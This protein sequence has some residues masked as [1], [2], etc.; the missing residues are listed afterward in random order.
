MLM[1]DISTIE[2]QESE[3]QPVEERRLKDYIEKF[4]YHLHSIFH[5]DE[6]QEKWHYVVDYVIICMIVLS[7]AEIFISTFNLNP[8]VKKLMF[9]IDML[10]LVFFTCEVTLRIWV[11]P[12]ANK[13]VPAW[14]ARCKY[15]F[16]FNGIIDM[17]STYPFY[18]QWLLPFPIAWMKLLRMGRTVR[19]FRITRYTK[20]WTLLKQAVYEKRNELVISMQFLI[21]ITF[22]LSLLLYFCEHEAQPEVYSDGFS[23]VAWSFAQYIGD[24]GRFGDTPPI[25]GFGKT[26][27]CIVGLLGIAMVAVPA[28]ILGNGFT[29]AIDKDNLSINR[30]K[31]N[32]LF[33]K[34]YDRPSEEYMPKPYQ[35]FVTI[36]ARQGL[37]DND[38][39]D[40][41]KNTK[42]FRI[43]NLADTRPIEETPVDQLAVER[44]EFT[45]DCKYGCFIDRNSNVTIIAPTGMYDPAVSYFAYYIAEMGGFNFISRE[46]GKKAPYKSFY[47]MNKETLLEEGAPEFYSDVQR[48][49]NRKNTW[50]FTIL[51]SSGCNEPAYDE[52]IHFLTGC[53]KEDPQIG[54]LVIDKTKFELFYKYFTETV[55]Q[56]LNIDCD[57]GN[58]HDSDERELYLRNIK[59]REGS[60]HVVVRVAWAQMLW[61]PNRIVLIKTFAKMM[62]EYFFDASVNYQQE[63]MASKNKNFMQ[64]FLINPLNLKNG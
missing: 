11:A 21:I 8:T 33:E 54:D 34:Q 31:L 7:S 22:I 37:T 49:L 42:G 3:E 39:S 41:V 52:H 10:T 29:E 59:K 30:E 19:I 53:S 16:S 15:M 60:S 32:N 43:I 18:L 64:K 57:L 48:L 38:V 35:S 5:L 14:K 56:D 26:I 62:R 9:W 58:H 46:F 20:S 1:E 50:S 51:P 55:S 23:T 6:H 27:A 25:T 44:Y 4:K 36:L 40:V 63:E 45:E 24:P 13:K 12:M 2:L 17:I 61:S 47:Y 28:S